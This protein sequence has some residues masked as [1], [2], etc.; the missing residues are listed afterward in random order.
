[1]EWQKFL[2]KWRKQHPDVSYRKALKKASK[3]YRKIKKRTS[4]VKKRRNRRR[5]NVS[6]DT[7]R[8]FNE[9]IARDRELVREMGRNR[10]LRG[11][12][13]RELLSRFREYGPRNL[14][15]GFG[16]KRTG[17]V[18]SSNKESFTFLNF[19]KKTDVKDFI[20]YDFS[21][22]DF[23]NDGLITKDEYE[24]QIR[25]YYKGIF[26]SEIYGKFESYDTDK[27]GY[28]DKIEFENSGLTEKLRSDPDPHDKRTKYDDMKNLFFDP[29]KQCFK[30]M[31]KPTGKTPEARGTYMFNLIRYLVESQGV[32][33]YITLDKEDPYLPVKEG[34]IFRAVCNNSDICQYHELIV[35]DYTAPSLEILSQF[36]E[37]VTD[38]FKKGLN[39]VSHCSAGMGRT[40]FM[41]LA[42]LL[43][44]YPE[45]IYIYEIMVI[46]SICIKFKDI[47]KGELKSISGYT[48]YGKQV[49]EA[50]ESEDWDKLEELKTVSKHKR[51]L[52]YTFDTETVS[53]LSM[54]KLLEE[55][56]SYYASEENFLDYIRHSNNYSKF[57]KDLN[58]LYD[59]MLVLYKY[60]M[61]RK[62]YKKMKVTDEDFESLLG[63]LGFEEDSIMELKNNVSSYF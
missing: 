38:S 35:D 19:N 28:L 27:N 55:K 63:S 17:I 24:E 15:R 12:L 49:K 25:K 10:E 9:Q 8:E 29:D 41:V 16:I 61:T 18:D 37:I 21:F 36:I 26:P 62:E 48:E 22:M 6:F 58:L 51:D 39:T 40:G 3:E 20:P 23:N 47:T 2:K 31:C 32:V 45:K 59:R 54:F 34:D 44:T 11:G 30:G 13:R 5:M 4:P 53:N 43:I 7:N 57:T 14:R 60:L 1:M 56:Y 46:I 42:Y 52:D 33:V 50:I